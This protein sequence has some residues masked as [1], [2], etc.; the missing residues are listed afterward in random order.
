MSPAET[1]VLSPKLL[2]GEVSTHRGVLAIKLSL[3]PFDIHQK[4]HVFIVKSIQIFH[5]EAIG[6]SVLWNTV[7]C[8]QCLSF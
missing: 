4:Y 2:L 6:F 8:V 7:M 1:A 3:N 5:K